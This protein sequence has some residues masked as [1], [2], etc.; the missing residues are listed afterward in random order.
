MNYPITQA[1][2]AGR[3]ITCLLKGH[4][5]KSS[6]KWRSD[7]AELG[8]ENLPY[9]HNGDIGN[10]YYQQLAWWRN[11]CVR[12]RLKSSEQWRPLHLEFWSGVKNGIFNGKIISE[13]LFIDEVYKPVPLWKRMVAVFPMTV[14]SAFE[15]WY[16]HFDRAPSFP[17]NVTAAVIYKLSEWLEVNIK[18]GQPSGVAN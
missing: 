1:Q 5:W 14:A 15:G 10:P 2:W 13:L 4:Q 17:L 18:E 16:I 6:L 3:E 8:S 9:R 12:C 7:W 11:K